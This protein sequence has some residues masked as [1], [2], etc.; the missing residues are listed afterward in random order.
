[1]CI[2][3]V[4]LFGT[5]DFD[6]QAAMVWRPQIEGPDQIGGA[7]FR[8]GEALSSQP[9][10]GIFLIVVGPFEEKRPE[11][12]IEMISL[13]NRTHLAFFILKV[14]TWVSLSYTS[15]ILPKMDIHYDP[16]AEEEALAKKWHWK[17]ILKS[18]STTEERCS[19]NLNGQTSTPFNKDGTNILLW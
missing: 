8:S 9:E 18:L 7:I 11:E 14:Q 13:S 5:H 16:T 19:P 2:S 4:L 10:V 15:D 3:N 12:Y 17:T 6:F 1:M